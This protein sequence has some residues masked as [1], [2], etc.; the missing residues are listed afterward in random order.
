MHA[1]ASWTRWFPA[2]AALSA[3]A[4][5]RANLASVESN[6]QGKVLDARDFTF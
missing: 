4:L 5:A 1:W 2:P 6:L 3:A